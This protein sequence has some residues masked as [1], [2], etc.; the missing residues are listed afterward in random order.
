M[1]YWTLSF[2]YSAIYLVG[3]VIIIC[4]NDVCNKYGKYMILKGA[5]NNREIIVNISTGNEVQIHLAQ[6]AGGV[7]Y[8]NCIS[9]TMSV[10]DITLN[11]LMVRLQ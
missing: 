5:S 11:H 6:L 7:E 2:I 10:Q 8:T 1:G 9:L 4:Q 3:H